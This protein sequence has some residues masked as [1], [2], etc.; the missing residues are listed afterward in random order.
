M[1][2]LGERLSLPP[3]LESRRGQIEAGLNPL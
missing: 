3:F 1:D 2:K